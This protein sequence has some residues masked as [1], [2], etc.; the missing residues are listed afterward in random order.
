MTDTSTPSDA[1]DAAGAPDPAAVYTSPELLMQDSALSAAEKRALL[2]QWALDLD[3]QLRAE[4]EGMSAADPISAG[5]EA[6]LAD[7]AARVRSL[8]ASLDQPRDEPL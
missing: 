7:E 1:P 3:R 4:E 8:M 2:E 6:R 5:R